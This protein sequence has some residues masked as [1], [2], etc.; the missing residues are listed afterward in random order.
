[1]TT[2]DL[3]LLTTKL[4]LGTRQTYIT[5]ALHKSAVTCPLSVV[6]GSASASPTRWSGWRA[7][8]R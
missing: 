1:M 8:Q 2:T 5:I 7:W 4:T 3:A 6:S